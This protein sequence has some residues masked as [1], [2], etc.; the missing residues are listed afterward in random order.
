MNPLTIKR[1]FKNASASVLAANAHDYGDGKPAE[2]PSCAGK[3]TP[4]RPGV[5]MGKI[6]PKQA[7]KPMRAKE[8]NKIEREYELMLKAQFPAAVIRWEAYTLRMANRATYTADYSVLHP[9]GILEFHEVKGAFVFA[10]GLVK[11]RIA[12]AMFP[13]HKFTLA[14]KKKDGWHITEFPN[15]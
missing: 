11:P 4:A 8:P 3:E 6:Q 1:L 9:N 2:A 5:E 15:R 7:A 13:L 12:A 14:Q 10:K